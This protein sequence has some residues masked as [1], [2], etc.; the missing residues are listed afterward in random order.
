LPTTTTRWATDGGTDAILGVLEALHTAPATPEGKATATKAIA[1]IATP[2]LTA[3]VLD[4]LSQD[5]QRVEEK[6]LGALV[7]TTRLFVAAN[8]SAVWERLERAEDV[9]TQRVLLDA[10]A[11]AGPTLLPLVRAKLR[12]SSWIIVKNAVALL[13]RVGGTPRD[14]VPI[15]R[16]PNERVRSE[17]MRALRTLQPDEASMDILVGYLGDS[18]QELRQAAR[19]ML[20]ADLLGLGAIVQLERIADDGDREEALRRR[21]I[22]VLGRST[23]DSA[24]EALLRLIQPRSLLEGGT[25]RELAA[26]AL[27]GSPAPRAAAF[28]EQGL[29]S[30]VRRVRKACERAAGKSG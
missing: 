23:L 29:Q 9:T 1:E 30:S 26:V 11:S 10:L 7:A 4:R 6:D 24:A 18:A 14:L 25:L 27:R 8:P 22:E 19:S 12:D 5:A 2:A 3:R 15:A 13:P 20:R 17:V 21:C 28:F 16:H